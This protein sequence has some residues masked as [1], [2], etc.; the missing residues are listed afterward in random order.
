MQTSHVFLYL[1]FSIEAFGAAGD[2][3]LEAFLRQTEH[4]AGQASDTYAAL[5]ATMQAHPRAIFFAHRLREDSRTTALAAAQAKSLFA[6]IHLTI[7]GGVGCEMTPLS[8]IRE[9]TAATARLEAL[10]SSLASSLHAS[11]PRFTASYLG[12]EGVEGSFE[13]L[14]S[15]FS[16]VTDDLRELR[17]W[18]ASSSSDGPRGEFIAHH[19]ACAGRLAEGRHLLRRPSASFSDEVAIAPDK[20]EFEFKLKGQAETAR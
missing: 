16:A 19:P 11:S 8:Q 7:K 17:A 5:N 18:L 9:L 14:V 10:Y 6:K 15:D 20:V 12:G 3:K 2:T 13:K 1:C 4:S